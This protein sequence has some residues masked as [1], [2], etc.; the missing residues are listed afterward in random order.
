MKKTTRNAKAWLTTAA[1]AALAAIVIAGFIGIN[2]QG[3]ANVEAASLNSLPRL[4]DSNVMALNSANQKIEG[5]VNGTPGQHYHTSKARIF[6]GLDEDA[7]VLAGET[8]IDRMTTWLDN[9]EMTPFII[10]QRVNWNFAGK[11]PRLPRNGTR[12]R[13]QRLRPLA[14]TPLWPHG[15]EQPVVRNAEAAARLEE[16]PQL[17]EVQ[18]RRRLDP[19]VARQGG[20]TRLAEHLR[21]TPRQAQGKLLL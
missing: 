13:N 20:P 17:P 5:L 6:V 12:A 18:G 3:G 14:G 1:V 11:A 15:V 10:G 19:H 4:G 21:G 16:Q 9:G 2:N 7:D 8:V